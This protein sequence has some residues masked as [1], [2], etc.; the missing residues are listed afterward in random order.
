[1]GTW[2]MMDPQVN[3]LATPRAEK[4]AAFVASQPCRG[5]MSWETERFLALATFKGVAQVS[6]P[7]TPAT[8]IT[9]KGYALSTVRTW[10][11]FALPY[12][13]AS[14]TEIHQVIS[15][16]QR[17]KAELLMMIM[18]E[19][20][21]LPAAFALPASTDIDLSH[22]RRKWHKELLDPLSGNTDA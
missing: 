21:Y 18:A 10:F 15:V 16:I 13:V 2:S 17:I 1:M 6:S 20:L 9:A 3:T 19:L 4:E 22:H 12:A 8:K 7:T 5:F 14:W 11:S